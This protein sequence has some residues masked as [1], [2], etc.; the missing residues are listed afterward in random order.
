MQK[1]VFV[2]VR[3]PQSLRAAIEAEA[4]QSGVSVSA[5]IRKSLI[6]ELF[7]SLPSDRDKRSG[8]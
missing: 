1:A 3:M 4:R 6:R 5:V 2:G 7:R 8:C